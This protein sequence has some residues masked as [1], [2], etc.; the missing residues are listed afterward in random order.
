MEPIS[1]HLSHIKSDELLDGYFFVDIDDHVGE[2]ESIFE[3]LRALNKL[4]EK[5]EE[6]GV[7]T[8]QPKRKNYA[9]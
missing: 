4:N 5:S 8:K 1:S 9:L 3:S 7:N 2:N 6:L